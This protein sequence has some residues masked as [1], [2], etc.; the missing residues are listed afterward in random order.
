LNCVVT[1]P[2]YKK[3]K[4]GIPESPERNDGRADK[5]HSRRYESQQRRNDARFEAKMESDKSEAKP[6]REEL[7]EKIDVNQAKTI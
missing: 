1:A 7:L 5:N 2:D 3:G 4:H 6:D